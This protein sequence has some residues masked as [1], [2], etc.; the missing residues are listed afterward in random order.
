MRRVV[1]R[2]HP[3]RL[4]AVGAVGAMGLAV[5]GCGSS[6]GTA[7]SA[8][9][10]AKGSATTAAMGNM[11]STTSI[12]KAKQ[13]AS[14][15]TFEIDASMP[16][17]Y[18]FPTSEAPSGYVTVKLVNN[19]TQM[20]H[21]AQLVKLHDGVSFAKFKSDL[22]GK[23]GEGAMM[24]DGTPAGGPNSAGPKQSSSAI[25]DLAPGATYAVVCNIPAPDGKPHYTHGMVSSFTVSTKPG[26]TTAPAAASTLKLID[27]GFEGAADVN[28]SKPVR[29]TNTGKAPHEVAI[30]GP[31][32]GKTLADIHANLFAKPGTTSGPPPYRAYGGVGAI[33]PGTSEVF[34]PK[35]PKGKYYLVCFVSG[36]ASGMQPHFMKGMITQ[37]TVS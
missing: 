2:F 37:I 16:Y 9:P 19:D 33:A 34:Q 18:S 15:P 35:L 31:A 3:A 8:S 21:Q 7:K 23:I 13:A 26:V 24:M 1:P 17:K 12:A 14:L 20:P 29:V 11:G 10:T 30:L 36:P 28:W 6:S 4:L 22:L 32:P 25:V 27:F 5:V